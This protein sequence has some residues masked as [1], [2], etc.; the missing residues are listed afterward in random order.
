MIKSIFQDLD[1]CIL[2]SVNIHPGQD[3]LHFDLED[4]DHSYFT[5]VRPCAVGLFDFYRSLVGDNN[6]FILTTSTRD[7][8]SKIIELAG[9]NISDSNLL[10]RDTIKK[11]S[12]SSAYG[13]S[14]TVS[15]KS[16]AHKDNIL[17]D[18]LPWKYN[19]SKMDMISI[20]NDRYLQT[21][22]YYGVNY[23]D[24]NFEKT[25]KEFVLNKYTN[26]H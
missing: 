12:Y 26:D 19:M 22:D 6:V 20:A 10:A 3:C 25:V 17:I 13:E 7:Y 14:A 16:I 15:M 2:H 9:F 1:E 23:P 5:M 4:D 11:H 18:N 21:R 24:D 8:A